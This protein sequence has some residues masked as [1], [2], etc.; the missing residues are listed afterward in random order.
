MTWDSYSRKYFLTIVT[1]MGL[2]YLPVFAAQ[3]EQDLFALSITQLMNVK[4]SSAS[5]QEELLSDVPASI[6]VI[7]QNS[8]RHSGATSIPEALRLAPTLQV[9]R[10][11]ASQYAISARGFNSTVSNKLLVLID[12]RTVYTPLFS[13]VFWDQQ[14]VL[15]E[16][17]ERIEVISGPGGTLWG[18]NA[19]NG[20]I[21]IITRPSSKTTGGLVGVYAGNEG[22]GLNT[23]YGNR[24]GADGHFRVYSKF[25]ERDATF[26]A[27]GS[28]QLDG[29]YNL[30]AGFR[31]DWQYSGSQFTVQGDTYQGSTEDRGTVLDIELGAIE[32]SGS[33]LLARWQK[34]LKNDA[35]MR[36][37]IYW[38]HIKR[39]DVILFQPR[40]DILDIEFQHGVPF[41][42]HK[43]L[44]GWGYRYGKDEVDPGLFSTFVPAS[45]ELDWKSLFVQD[46]IALSSQLKATVGLKIEGNDYTGTEYLPSARLAWKHSDESLVWTAFSRAVRAPSRLDREVYFPA[47]PNSIVV[48]GPNFESE[49]ADVLELGYR[50]QATENLAYSATLYYHD[51]D[52]L[53][54]GSAPPVELE[55]KIEGEAYGVEFWA[56][57]ALSPRWRLSVGGF[58]LHKDLRLKSDSTDPVGI[59]NETLANDPKYRALVRV[60]AQLTNAL[61]MQVSAEHNA[62]LPYPYVPSYTSIN[63]NLIWKLRSGP[64]ISFTVRNIADEDHREFGQP[65]AVSGEFG[66]LA[67]LKLLWR[68]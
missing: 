60:T 1:L 35:D 22:R 34:P 33:N 52:K 43:L 48:G 12:G 24:M 11:N 4:V 49:I 5:K 16:D 7:T 65:A 41:N 44:W 64:E 3:S 45:R 68:K 31:T 46:E 6:F 38:D 21:N 18:S 40:G 20:V 13:G 23:R 53:R 56:A 25:Y 58:H 61:S 2:M 19:V 59:D 26:R 47:P 27:D 57:Y 30:Q 9:A 67:W 66:R 15:L 8:I 42:S 10:I 32:M 63:G 62:D 51:W 55:N 14:D 39:R 36:L 37:Q 50:S 28:S 29:V 54:S 17:V